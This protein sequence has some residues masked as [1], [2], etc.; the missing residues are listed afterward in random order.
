MWRFVAGANCPKCKQ[1]DRLQIMRQN[2]QYLCRCVNCDYFA[3]LNANSE[4]SE[5][6]LKQIPLI[7]LNQI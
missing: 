5:A 3:Q 6:D 2:D 4:G 1:T 7:N